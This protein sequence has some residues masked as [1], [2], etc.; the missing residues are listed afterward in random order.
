MPSNFLRCFK[1]ETSGNED[2]SKIAKF[3]KQRCMDIAQ[4]ILTTIQTWHL[5]IVANAN[6]F[7]GS[8]VCSKIAKFCEKTSSHGHRSEYVDDIQRRSRFAQKGHNWWRI[9]YAYDSV[10]KVQLFQWKRPE[11]HIKLGEMWRFSSIFSSIA[12]VWCRM[13]SCHKV[14]RSIRNTT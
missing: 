8:E 1:H 4:E 14:V 11:E 7:Y 5:M 9:M 3:W 6:N 12:M 13:N 2:F 10:T